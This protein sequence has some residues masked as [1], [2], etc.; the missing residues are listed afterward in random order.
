MT[1][2][3]AS[4]SMQPY[5]VY[6]LVFVS[7]LILTAVT[8]WA[9]G[10]PLGGWNVPVALLIASVKAALVSLFFMHLRFEGSWIWGFAAFSIFLL[11]P[12]ILLLAADALHGLGAG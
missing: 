10:F 9:S 4:H 6:V 11:F 7:L 5:R 2:F 1:D 8:L 12:L 3:H